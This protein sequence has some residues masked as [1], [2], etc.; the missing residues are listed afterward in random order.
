M[1]ITGG[2]VR[3]AIG[4]YHGNGAEGA[5]IGGATAAAG[6]KVSISGGTVKKAS[7]GYAFGTATVRY[8]AVELSG[9]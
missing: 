7:G 2:S 9:N 8:N 3:D 6:N 1:E 5:V 4:G